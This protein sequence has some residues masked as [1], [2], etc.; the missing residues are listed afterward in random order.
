[1]S[2]L[3]SPLTVRGVRLRN[4]IGVAPMCQ[5]RSVDGRP[6]D[7]QLVHLGARA[8][9]GAALVVSEAT[10]ISPAARSS[11]HDTGLWCDAHVDAWRPITAFI[12]SQD[13]VAA[14]QLA[15]AGPKASAR[16]PGRSPRGSLSDDEGGWQPIGPDGRPFAPLYRAPRALD[17]AGIDNVVDD[18]GAAAE[19]A[20]AAGFTAVEI[21]AAHGQLLH[22]FLS[23]LSNLRRDEYGGA[24]SG[25]AR[26]LRAAVRAVRA[27]VGDEILLLTR[28]SAADQAPG[29]WTLDDC[30]T[31]A[32]MLAADGVDIVDC[33]SAG[34]QNS[35][36]AQIRRGAGLPTATVGL[37]TEPE[38]AEQAVASGDADLVLLGRELLRDPQWPLRAAA[39][40]GA[41]MPVPD[42]YRH[43]F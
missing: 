15:H 25:R 16:V 22:S 31:L 38:Q 9:G 30:V 39:K 17:R 40:L 20:V 14:V 5:Y 1:V 32:R 8:V 23:P 19:R 18:F 7:W 27:A 36:A 4:R 6:D 2:V 34:Y 29:G 41:P 43:A 13:A 33:A 42:A 24:L 37:I 11:P 3:F 12:Q 26:L 21:H 28:I 10:A 35:F